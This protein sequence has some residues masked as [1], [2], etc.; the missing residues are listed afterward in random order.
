MV[1]TTWP[2]TLGFALLLISPTRLVTLGGYVA[3]A[4]AGAAGYWLARR[5]FD[6]P[7]RWHCAAVGA[8]L[9]IPRA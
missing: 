1:A 6:V 8:A 7:T 4:L 2:L 9:A 5:P 3:A